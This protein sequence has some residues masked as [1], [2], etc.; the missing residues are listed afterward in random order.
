MSFSAGS[1]V[2]SSLRPHVP[3]PPIPAPA[4]GAGKDRRGLAHSHVL[5]KPAHPGLGPHGSSE[6]C[7]EKLNQGL[8][9]KNPRFG[10]P[11]IKTGIG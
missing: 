2:V 5:R 7:A 4:W 11:E 8:E 6:L 9:F 3:A 1:Q 10:H